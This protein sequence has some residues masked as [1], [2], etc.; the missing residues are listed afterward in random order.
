MTVGRALLKTLIHAAAMMTLAIGL[1]VSV[2]LCATATPVPRLDTGDAP[3]ALLAFD[4]SPDGRYLVFSQQ[5]PPPRQGANPVYH[6]HIFDLHTLVMRTLATNA[7]GSTRIRFETNDRFAFLRTGTAGVSLMDVSGTELHRF[8]EGEYHSFC[9]GV[10]FMGSGSQ[11]DLLTP[12]HEPI[13]TV[14]GKGGFEDAVCSADRLLLIFKQEA[15]LRD[16]RTQEPICSIPA[17]RGSITSYT[18]GALLGGNRLALLDHWSGV[19]LFDACKQ[20]QTLTASTMVMASGP[21]LFLGHAGVM[22]AGRNQGP[23]TRETGIRE[24]DP[25]G[26][27][28]GDIPY[29]DSIRQMRFVAERP[30]ILVLLSQEG[31]IRFLNVRTGRG[32]TLTIRRE[33]GHWLLAGDDGAYHASPGSAPY[34]YFTQGTRIIPAGPPAASRN[35]Y[36]NFIGAHP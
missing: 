9:N 30:D 26:R 28:L 3:A 21:H 16:L 36:R 24:Y 29:P 12:A 14:S 32:L 8:P 23:H 20:T 19:S 10:R 1:A 2:P 4:I 22:G 33:P 15:Q 27:H 34:L 11:V 18:Q 13:R 17:L 35:L 6:L 7:A 31:T 25:N 5:F